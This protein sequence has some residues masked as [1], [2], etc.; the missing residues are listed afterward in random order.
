MPNWNQNSL[1]VSGLTPNQTTLMKE[2]LEG[3]EFLETFIPSPDWKNIPNEE[4]VL[5]EERTHTHTNRLGETELSTFL[6]W[7]KNG[8]WTSDDRW[9][10]WRTKHWGTKWDIDGVGRIEEVDDELHCEFQTAWCPPLE[11]FKIISS[12]FPLA[13][14]FLSFF[15]VEPR[16]ASKKA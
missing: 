3:E 15:D 9:Y 13:Y 8:E 2:A 6:G 4:G 5:P 11:A 12:H 1:Q 10:D 7:D 16:R 14:F